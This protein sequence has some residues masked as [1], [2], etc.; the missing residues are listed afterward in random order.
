MASLYRAWECVRVLAFHLYATRK[1]TLVD[2]IR[3]WSR[4]SP[5]EQL[6]IKAEQKAQE[7]KDQAAEALKLK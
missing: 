4:K 3:S 5:E 7:I 2:S 6:K 1:L